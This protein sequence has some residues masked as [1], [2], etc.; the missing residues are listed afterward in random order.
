MAGSSG[1]V[2][3]VKLLAVM[4]LVIGNGF[5]VA[6]EFALVAVRR[7]RVEQMVVEERPQSKNLLRAVTNLDA[8]LAATQLGVTMSSLGL[9]WLGEPAIAE[10]VIPIFKQI[11]P[12]SIAETGAHTLAIVV[13]F[14]LITALHIVLGE[15]APKSLALQQPET[16]ALFV[17]R[18]LDLYLAIFRPAVHL[19]NNLGNVVLRALGL[20]TGNAE[21][22]V[23][24]PDEIRLLVSASRQA[25]LLGEAE[26]DVVERVLRLGDQQVSAFMTPRLDIEWLDLEDP[27]ATLQQIIMTSVHSHF[28]VCQGSVDELL[29]FVKA[30][31]VLA[32]SMNE[33]FSVAI[34]MRSLTQPLYIPEGTKA[35]HALDMFKQSGSYIATVVDEY[36]AIQGLVTLND[37]LEAVVGDIQTGNE[38]SDVQAMHCADGSWRLEGMLSIE[39]FKDIFHIRETRDDEDAN[40]QTLGGFIMSQLGHVPVASESFEW[41]KLRVEVLEMDGNRVDKVLVMPI[42]VAQSGDRP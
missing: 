29:G 36:G 16:T 41:N 26:E 11:L 1:W 19:L 27:I 5:F 34:L 31:A 8:Y 4:V 20:Q 42:S 32:A 18:L 12:E 30:R 3:A 21:E 2:I 33:P 38:P 17:I 37:I 10:L 22:L 6:A 25:G 9:G 15:L 7:S 23:H 24:S 40:Y 35:F 13:A 28:P 39:E 14:T